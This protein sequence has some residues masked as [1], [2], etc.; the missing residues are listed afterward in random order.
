M[1]VRLQLDADIRPYKLCCLVPRYNVQTYNWQKEN[2][3]VRSGVFSLD[4]AFGWETVIEPLDMQ[5]NQLCDM[6]V[7][8]LMDRVVTRRL[9][10]GLVS[11]R[12]I[13]SFLPKWCKVPST[14]DSELTES[15]VADECESFDSMK[16]KS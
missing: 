6:I 13:T 9:T 8:P 14:F 4:A 7:E 16:I 5:L 3:D 11:W 1:E 10:S 12:P 2:L 15:E